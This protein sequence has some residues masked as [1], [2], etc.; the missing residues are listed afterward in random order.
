MHSEDCKSCLVLE[1]GCS[2]RK[3]RQGS[4]AA[5]KSMRFGQHSSPGSVTFRAQRV[6]ENLR[7]QNPALA[8]S[9]PNVIFCKT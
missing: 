9:G 4:G 6:W 3:E 5:K 7:S 8:H 1:G 2:R